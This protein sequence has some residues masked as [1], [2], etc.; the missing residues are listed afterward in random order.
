M[1]VA[2]RDIPIDVRLAAFVAQAAPPVGPG[3]ASSEPSRGETLERLAGGLAHELKNPLG[4]LALGLAFLR[5]H[6]LAEDPEVTEILADLSEAVTRASAA[7]AEWLAFAAEHPP[8][9]TRG[10][11]ERPLGHALALARMQRCCAG[12]GVEVESRGGSTD[13]LVDGVLALELLVN[14]LLDVAEVTPRGGRVRVRTF[15][16]GPRAMEA[17]GG[18]GEAR[19]R[20]V[21]CEVES[22]G[23]AEGD[24]AGGAGAPEVG[25]CAGLARARRLVEGQGGWLRSARGRGGGARV[26]VGFPAAE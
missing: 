2:P 4:V 19:R 10:P 25:A 3:G 17:R 24:R 21:V 12:V 5:K 22:L 20:W 11:I 1:L 14:V 9:P 7:V 16:L 6:P 23:P 13:V 15:A 18:S 26:T 8:G